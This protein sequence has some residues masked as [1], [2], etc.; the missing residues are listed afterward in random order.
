VSIAPSTQ[1]RRHRRLVVWLLAAA[2]A[3]GVGATARTALMSAHGHVDV[4]DVVVACVAAT[5]CVVAVGIAA[6]AVRGY[7]R[8]PL[9]LIPAPAAPALPLVA[10]STGFLARAGPLAL[11]QVFRL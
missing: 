1:L 8:R 5:A 10:S 2:L 4:S 3:L 9:W 7:A 6:F 11:L